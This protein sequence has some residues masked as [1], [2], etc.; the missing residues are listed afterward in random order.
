L[1]TTERTIR[2]ASFLGANGRPFY[3][4]VVRWL[5]EATGLP[6]ALAEPAGEDPGAALRAGAVEAVFCCG[7]PYALAAGEGAALRLLGAPVMAEARYQDRPVY[8]SDFIVRADADIG[9]FDD[10]RGRTFAFNEAASFSGYVLPLDHLRELGLAPGF[11]GR[12]VA[13]GS[14]ARSMDAVEGGAADAAAIDSVVLA[15]EVRQRPRRALRVIASAGPAPMPPA[16]AARP[17]AWPGGSA[18]ADRLRAALA[19]MHTDP[20][21]RAALALGGARR[22]AAVADSDYD[23]IRMTWERVRGQPAPAG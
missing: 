23:A 9:C 19:R 11:F 15:A 21:G 5:G 16:V 8:F 1:K 18:T 10:L 13:T 20:A 17:E 12:W 6:L 7:L 2:F 22:F 14:H 3:E 4:A